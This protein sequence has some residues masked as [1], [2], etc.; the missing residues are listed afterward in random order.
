MKSMEASRTEDTSSEQREARATIQRRR[1][2][3]D[4]RAEDLYFFYRAGADRYGIAVNLRDGTVYG[5]SLS[6]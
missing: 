3:P 5:W 2:R 4:E 6:R 1:E